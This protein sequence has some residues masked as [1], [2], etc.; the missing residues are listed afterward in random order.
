[1]PKSA[2]NKPRNATV[3]AKRGVG[4]AG[5][6]GGKPAPTAGV[7][8]LLA[9]VRKKNREAANLRKRLAEA[10]PAAREALA[11]AERAERAEAALTRERLARRFNLPGELAERLQGDS[12]ADLA[13]DAKRLSK[14]LAANHEPGRVDVG[15]GN[16]TAPETNPNTLFRRL[17]RNAP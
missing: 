3:P 4:D 2:S 8:K 16:R 5:R 9:Q 10:E 14:V 11:A 6:Q 17:A 12:E 1:M 13:A 7:E 15:Q